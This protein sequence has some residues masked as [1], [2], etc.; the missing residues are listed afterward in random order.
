MDRRQK[1]YGL[2]TMTNTLRGRT[3]RIGLV[4]ALAVVWIFV[5]GPVAANAVY[6]QRGYFN[7]D[8]TPSIRNPDFRSGLRDWT[9]ESGS[10]VQ[11]S[12]YYR[13]NPTYPYSVYT[14]GTSRVTLRQDLT[15]AAVDQIKGNYVSFSFWFRSS[16]DKGRAEVAVYDR[17]YEPVCRCYIGGW[18]VFNSPW[19]AASDEAGN[20][21]WTNVVV[22]GFAGMSASQAYV[23]ILIDDFG[24]SPYVASYVDD[25]TLSLFDSAVGS[26]GYG[27]AALTFSVWK[28]DDYPANTLYRAAYLSAAMSGQ[29]SGRYKVMWIQIRLE[30]EPQYD[31]CWWIFCTRKTSQDG[32]LWVEGVAQGNDLNI[33]V[34]PQDQQQERETGLTAASI[35]LGIVTGAATAG[36]GAAAGFVVGA[37]TDVG[38]TLLFDW[39]GESSNQF[40]TTAYGPGA[41]YSTQVRWNYPIWNHCGRTPNPFVS[42]ATGANDAI[43]VYRP[44]VVGYRLKLVAEIGWGVPAQTAYC[45]A[46]TYQLQHVATTNLVGYIYP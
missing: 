41:D 31:D 35:G 46:R 2:R 19:I 18:N 28:V 5:S 42:R 36:L 23:R 37:V 1:G 45:S 40:D 30:L 15:S 26:S 38:T 10:A 11:T 22:R 6:V 29:A 16:N 14:S 20:L 3:R 12:T 43:W 17:Y 33:A 32:R 39:I 27:S 21:A 13:S 44:G 34:N 7:D 4:A 24:P 25:A 9:V 8:T